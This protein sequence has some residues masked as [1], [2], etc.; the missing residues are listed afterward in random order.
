M[1]GE[2]RFTGPKEEVSSAKSIESY[3]VANLGREG[4]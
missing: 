3:L 4:S 2:W 1:S